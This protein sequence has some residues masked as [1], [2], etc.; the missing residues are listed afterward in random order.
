MIGVI[1]TYAFLIVTLMTKTI[2]VTI[3]FLPFFAPVTSF[4]V[5]AYDE[6]SKWDKCNA[7]LPISRTVT[8]VEKY[9]LLLMNVFSYVIFLSILLYVLSDAEII[10]AIKIIPGMLLLGLTSA[11]IAFPFFF[12]GKAKKTLTIWIIASII[13]LPT[14][15]K[16]IANH[17][18]DYLIAIFTVLL[19]VCSLLL[20]IN[21]YKKR[22]F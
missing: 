4:F 11:L 8:V 20:S 15:T 18:N 22:E 5:L 1:I 17:E 6:G 12:K 7:I 3:I 2:P 19:F 13:F 10:E 21:F 16:I 9:V 14:E